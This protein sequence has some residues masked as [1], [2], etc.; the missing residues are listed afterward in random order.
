M[1]EQATPAS[2][3]Y[4]LGMVAYECLGWPA[5]VHRHAA[6]GSAGPPRSPAAA[7]ACLSTRG[8]VCAFV[9]RLTAK[10][11]AWRPGRAG[12]GRSWR[13]RLRDG[14]GAET[15]RTASVA[16]PAAVGRREPW[17]GCAVTP[18]SPMPVSRS[19]L[20]RRHRAGEASSGSAST[21]QRASARPSSPSATSPDSGV[22]GSAC[23]LPGPRRRQAAA[24]Q[25]RSATLMHGRRP[26]R[27]PPRR[28]RG[29]HGRPGHR[30]RQRPARTGRARTATGTATVRPVLGTRGFTI[31]ANPCLR[32]SNASAAGQVAGA[33]R[34]ACRAR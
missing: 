26:S 31:A 7:A 32:S 16:G 21:P 14:L 9:M 20:G 23:H 10:D 4:S 33:S 34:V 6:G 30:P 19:P 3:L 5:A 17:D 29:R 22:A 15:G 28:S 25:H 13:H 27:P 8:G 2:D 12:R 1:G 18:S 11:P 24:Q